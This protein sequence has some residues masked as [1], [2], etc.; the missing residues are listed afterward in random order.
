MGTFTPPSSGQFFNVGGIACDSNLLFILLAPKGPTLLSVPKDKVRP[1]TGKPIVKIPGLYEVSGVPEL[2]CKIRYSDNKD[3]LNFLSVALVLHREG[4]AAEAV[5]YA[6]K[7]LARNPDEL[8]AKL[9]VLCNEPGALVGNLT[10]KSPENAA[11]LALWLAQVKKQPLEGLKITSLWLPKFREHEALIGVNFLCAFMHY[12]YRLIMLIA[13]K[14]AH[15]PYLDDSTPLPDG[16]LE[17]IEKLFSVPARNVVHELQHSLSGM[18]VKATGLA[19]DV[20]RLG[21][22]NFNLRF[23]TEPDLRTEFTGNAPV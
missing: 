1:V 3:E 8:S 17:L 12:G 2:A 11:N 16:T 10:P 6:K 4:R 9:I 18:D 5:T 21:G 22:A 14:E 13:G 7:A 20:L 19:A 15:L 23:Y